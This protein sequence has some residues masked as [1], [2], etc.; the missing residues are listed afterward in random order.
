[1]IASEYATDLNMIDTATD[2]LQRGADIYALKGNPDKA[3]DLL[4]RAGKVLESSKPDKALG[5][6]NKAINLLYPKGTPEAE[7]DKIHPSIIE[8]IR[9]TFKFL[10]AHDKLQL[11]LEFAETRCIPVYE[12]F[13]QESSTCKTMAIVVILNLSLGDVVQANNKLLEYFSN[14]FFLKSG[15]C[16]LVDNLVQAFRLSD[17]SKLDEAM[18]SHE[19]G[20]LDPREAIALVKML[21]LFGAP[22]PI[23]DEML[24]DQ[25]ASNMRDLMAI[26][27]E[28]QPTYD[29]KVYLE[30]ESGGEE[31]GREGGVVEEPNPLLSDPA[32]SSSNAYPSTTS[33][34]DA[35]EEDD[36][37]VC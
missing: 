20:F 7:I 37:N 28:Q 8:M 18:Q 4:F 23:D 30:G 25:L 29:E 15:E 5:K 12:A 24:A 17:I 35:G 6:F 1:M 27:G 31:D 21:S 14:S 13:E 19:L 11:A 3:A 22:E 9:H 32:P 2:Y 36:L 33:Y 16:R 34:D 26:A 10:L